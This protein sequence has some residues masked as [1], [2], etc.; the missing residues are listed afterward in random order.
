MIALHQLAVMYST[1]VHQEVVPHP[2][3]VFLHH[4]VAHVLVLLLNVLNVMWCLIA[5]RMIS[6]KAI[7]KNQQEPQMKMCVNTNV[8]TQV[9][10]R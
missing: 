5:R 3:P 2:V 10:V 6:M 4:L 8:R 1:Q 9:V 7:V